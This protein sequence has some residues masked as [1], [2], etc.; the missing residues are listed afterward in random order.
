LILINQFKK[1]PKNLKKIISKIGKPVAVSIRLIY[2]KVARTKDKQLK[3]S[4]IEDLDTT[5]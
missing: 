1:I 4:A 2:N 5:L 3:L